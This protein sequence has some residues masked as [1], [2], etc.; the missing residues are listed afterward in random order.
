MYV[1]IYFFTV[2]FNIESLFPEVTEFKKNFFFFLWMDRVVNNSAFF[3]KSAEYF[4]VDWQ[5]ILNM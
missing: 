3:N 2:W 1:I 5:C 4:S